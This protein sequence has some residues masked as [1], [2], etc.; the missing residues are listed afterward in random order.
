MARERAF[1]QYENYDSILKKLIVLLSVLARL[2]N[3]NKTNSSFPSPLPQQRGYEAPNLA[4]V[5][6]FQFI[7]YF[8]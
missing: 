5:C 1:K 7:R 3:S 8:L 4:K 6:L 2:E